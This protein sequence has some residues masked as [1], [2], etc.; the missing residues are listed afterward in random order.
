[1]NNEFNKAVNAHTQP[2]IISKYSTSNPNAL[3]KEVLATLVEKYQLFED[4]SQFKE[5]KHELL[6]AV[7]ISDLSA[8]HKE[9]YTREITALDDYPRLFMF[10][11]QE[12]GGL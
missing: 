11:E 8:P 9:S 12:V 10:L 2:N 7:K 1:M 6:L 3:F 4:Y 5:V